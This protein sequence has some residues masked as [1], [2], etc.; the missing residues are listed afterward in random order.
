MFQVTFLPIFRSSVPPLPDHRPAT[1]GVQ[2]IISCI[3]QTKTPEDGQ[4]CCP[5]HAE[6][7][8]IYQ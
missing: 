2:H 6:V 5:K 3:A 8:C 4:N 7:N 1:Y